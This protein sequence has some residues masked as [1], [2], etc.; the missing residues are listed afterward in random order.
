MI[1]AVT[2][3]RPPKIGGYDPSAPLR[4]AVRAAIHDALVRLQPEKG[5]SGMAL[6]VDQDFAEEC[7]ALGIPFLAA[8]PFKNQ[9]GAWPEASRAHYD[10]LL[11]MAAEVVV[12]SGGAY[13]TWKMQARNVWMV[14]A[15]TELLAVWD[16]SSGGTGNCVTYAL[17]KKR[18]IHRIDPTKLLGDGA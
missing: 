9:S 12:V 11:E 4:V 13:A 18:P 14:D 8:V 2:G 1:L 3:H 6:G 5:I 15:C 7:I 16:G 10:Y 17:T